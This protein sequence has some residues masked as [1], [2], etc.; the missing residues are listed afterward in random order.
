[1]HLSPHIVLLY[2]KNAIYAF[3]AIAIYFLVSLHW[4]GADCSPK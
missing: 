1:M 4:Y 2:L 3:I